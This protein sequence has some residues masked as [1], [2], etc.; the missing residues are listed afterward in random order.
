MTQSSP[1]TI[2]SRM[3]KSGSIIYFEGD[4]SEF[5][6]IL[7]S[8]K[9]MLKSTNL[10]SGE[11]IIESVK[12]GE[13][14]GVKS[15]L[16]K[17]PREE[18]AQTIGDTVVLVLTLQD[19]ERLILK[20]VEVVKKMLRVFSNQLRRIHKNVRSAMS[21][22][23]AINPS[24]ELYKIGEYYY[25]A[26]VAAQASYAFKKYLDYYPDNEFAAEAAKRI[27]AIKNGQFNISDAKAA[28]PASAPTAM[29]TA[30]PPPPKPVLDTAPSFQTQSFQP[31]GAAGFSFD[32]APLS[33]PT[34]APGYIDPFAS[35]N[36]AGGLTDELSDFLST[37]PFGGNT[38]GF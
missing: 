25:K 20:N 19:F 38:S 5:I 10:N 34:A 28:A 4:K 30:P 27:E 22:H 21:S 15:A 8:G 26:G 9:L 18:T 23:E 37:D 17:Y 1:A 13:F 3:Y 14:F 2:N 7:K 29:P 12:L 35:D 31:Q 36:S 24:T 6:Y 32:S 16:G 11:E 33:Q